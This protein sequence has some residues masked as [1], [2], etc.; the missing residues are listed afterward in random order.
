M[1]IPINEFTRSLDHGENVGCTGVYSGQAMFGCRSTSL[2]AAAEAAARVNAMLIAKGKLKT[3]TLIVP[4]KTKEITSTKSSQGDLFTAEVEINDAPLSARNLLTRGHTQDEINKYSGAAVSTRGRYLTFEEKAKNSGERPL[5]LYVQ[6]SEKEAVDLG[7]QRIQEIIQQH[8]NQQPP[9]VATSVVP[10]CISPVV[11]TSSSRSRPSKFHSKFSA[12]NP[13]GAQ[14][15]VLRPPPLMSLQTSMPSMEKV[16]VCLD[17]AGPGFDLRNKVVGVGGA[18]LHYIRNESGAMVGKQ[19]AQSL[20]DTLQQEFL[21][22]HQQQAAQQQQLGSMAAAMQQQQQQQQQAPAMHPVAQGMHQPPPSTLQQQQQQPPTHMLPPPPPHMQAMVPPPHHQ[23]QQFQMMP[24]SL[25]QMPPS[26]Q[27]PTITAMAP[28]QPPPTM[29]MVHGNPANMVQQHPPPSQQQAQQQAQAIMQQ[30]QQQYQH[31]QQQYAPMQAAG[32]GAPPM[33]VPFPGYPGAPPPGALASQQPPMMQQQQ[34]AMGMPSAHHHQQQQMHMGQM[35]PPMGKPPPH[36]RRFTEH[37][38]PE[39]SAFAGG[40][41]MA[42]L[43]GQPPPPPPSHSPNQQ[44]QQAQQRE[45]KRG[46]GE[47]DMKRRKT[48]VVQTSSMRPGLGYDPEDPEEDPGEADESERSRQSQF[49]ARQA[50]NYTQK[51]TFNHYSS[52]PQLYGAQSHFQQ[53]QQQTGHMYQPPPPPPPSQQQH[54]M[55]PPPQQLAQLL[56][57]PPPPPPQMQQQQQQNPHNAYNAPPIPPFNT[58]A[59][60]CNSNLPFWMLPQAGSSEWA[61]ESRLLDET[62]GPGPAGTFNQSDRVLHRAGSSEMLGSEWAA[63]SRL[64]DET[65]GPGPAETLGTDNACTRSLLPAATLSVGSL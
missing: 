33:P 23:S 56:P 32:T 30:Q 34:Q 28:S 25:Q 9:P 3:P 58:G 5:Y 60:Q 45:A 8:L 4:T 44:Q 1:F 48:G 14:Q 54:P 49:A 7:V 40:P 46:Q 37:A 12:R 20:V 38:D 21:Q 64:L 52:K 62:H 59:Y 10:A 39:E 53:Q 2:E 63:E 18:N 51:T 6:A 17:H 42:S 31:Q 11:Q 41:G 22:W 13:N 16:F 61:A 57:P 50:G 35:P 27:A 15:M 36:K 65:H 24:T 29:H 19:L 47:P 26:M 55:G 43:M